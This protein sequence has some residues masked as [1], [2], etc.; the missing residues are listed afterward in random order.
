[1]CA[2]VSVHVCVCACLQGVCVYVCICVCTIACIVLYDFT[3]YNHQGIHPQYCLDVVFNLL[4]QLHKENPSLQVKIILHF[5]KAA[6]IANAAG[7]HNILFIEGPINDYKE[8]AVQIKH[9]CKNLML[10]INSSITDPVI[11]KDVKI[12][13]TN[14]ITNVLAFIKC[15]EESPAVQHYSH[16]INTVYKI[17]LVLGVLQSIDDFVKSVQSK[18]VSLSYLCNVNLSA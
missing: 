9:V 18:L 7:G 8:E 1:M 6:D 16:I 4:R 17:Q 12:F 3:G 11:V 5:L 10:M 14:M 13:T 2:S 15:I